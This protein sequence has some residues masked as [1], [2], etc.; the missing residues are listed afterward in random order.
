MKRERKELIS[1]F[2]HQ[3]RFSFFLAVLSALL[4]AGVN[5]VI[6]WLLQQMIDAISGVPGSLGL[7]TL[8]LMLGGVVGLILLGK[9]ITYLS[10]PRFLEK[11]M[12]QYKDY[13]F[14][15]LTQKSIAAFCK[16][17]TS[18]YLSAFSNDAAVIE[19][20]YL[21]AQF[22]ILHNCIVAVGA[23]IMML[24]YSPIMTGIS[25]AFFLLPIGASLIAGNRIAQAERQASDRNGVLVSTLKD[26]LTGFSVMKSFKAEKAI[27]ALFAK[28]NAAAEQAKC[29]K[30]EWATVVNTLA[31]VAGVVAQLGTFLAGGILVQYGFQITPGILIVFLDLTGNIIYPIQELPEQLAQRKAAMALIDKLAAALQD[32]VREAGVHLTNQHSAE[33]QFKN[34]S[35]GYEDGNNILQQISATFEAGKSYAIVG[36][37]GSGKSTLLN[38][39]MGS[40]ENYSGEICYDGREIRT[41]S[42]DSLYDGI[43]MI[44]QNVFVFNASIRDNITM[45]HGFPEEEVNRAIA[46]SGLSKLIAERG[47]EYLCGE[48]GSGL[49][50]GEKQRISIARSLLKKSHVLLVDEATAALDAATAYQVA[51][52]ILDL[53]CMT[54]IVV[55]HNLDAALLKRYDC[56]LA[57]KNGRIVESGTF[58]Q[59]MAEKNYFY[60]LFTVS[61]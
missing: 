45:F 32:N 34:V 29:G 5:L 24:V 27:A 12:R 41:I 48:N 60:S 30:R 58:D 10:K 49:S 22:D 56:I 35:F 8:G 9:G 16:E 36:A 39:M 18:Q 28:N 2:F 44:Q 6:S 20:S 53:D 23:L 43:S 7:P 15:K 25:C 19:K 31:G 42:S 52:S 47:E 1:Q 40:H 59:L 55:T 17:D 57:L 21:E 26:S 33:I 37:S 54:R 14:Q 50:G 61:Q 4:I 38:L 13:A 11:A 51:T 46:L 3:N